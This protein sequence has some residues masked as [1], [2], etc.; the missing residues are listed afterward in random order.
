MMRND[1]EQ[2]VKFGVDQILKSSKFTTIEKDVLAA[3]L[4]EDSY[5]LE[6]ARFMLEEFKKGD[7]R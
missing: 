6:E 4:K 7:V 1:F 3:I 2:G 5:S